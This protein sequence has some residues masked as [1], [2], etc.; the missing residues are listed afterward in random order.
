MT[1]A[2]G[3]AVGLGRL[4]LAAISVAI[5]WVILRLLLKIE[6]SGKPAA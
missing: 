5:A 3:I 1:A 6:S 2:V 4:G